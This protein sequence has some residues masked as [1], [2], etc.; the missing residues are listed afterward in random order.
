MIWVAP[1][2]LVAVWLL[3]F[4][5]LCVRVLK[6]KDKREFDGIIYVWESLPALILISPALLLGFI[7]LWMAERFLRGIVI[8]AQRTWR[9]WLAIGRP[10]ADLSA[11]IVSK[12]S[13]DIL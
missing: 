7:V 8:G 10:A 13:Q 2:Y 1:A 5:A 3:T 6:A 11:Y 4:P 12:F 9:A